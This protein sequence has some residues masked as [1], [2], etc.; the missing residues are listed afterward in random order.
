LFPLAPKTNGGDQT[1]FMHAVLRWFCGHTPWVDDVV[2]LPK[3]MKGEVDPTLR[4]QVP[5]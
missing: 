3:A 5:T 2:A 1:D 4:A